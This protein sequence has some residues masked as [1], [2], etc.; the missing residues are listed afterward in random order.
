MLKKLPKIELHCH[1]DGSVRPQTIIDIAKEENIEIPSNELSEIENMVKVPLNCDS[2][3][4][5]L[6]RF[7]L[8]NKV[9]QSKESLKRI[10]FE[11]LEDANS[12]NLKYMEIRFAPLLHTL[13]GLSVSEVIES[14]IDGIKEAEKK[15]PIKAN[16]ILGCMRTMTLDDAIYV[17]EEGKKFL[18]K[19]VVAIDL[20]GAEN[21]GFA[22]EFKEAIDLARSFGYR[23]TIHAGEAASGVNVLEAVEILKA[24]RI[25]H[26]IGIRDI[27]EAYEIVK[28]KNIVLEMCPTSNVQTNAVNSFEDHPFYKFY[29]DGLKV[30]LNTDN[31]TVSNINLTK[32]F[33]NVDSVFEMSEE[34]YKNL[35]LISVDSTFADDNTKKWLRKFI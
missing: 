5:Y 24:E 15:Y 12:E 28:N 22:I 27:K 21:E 35:Y 11:L 9:M 29:K 14:I 30:T 23:V 18:N 13:N 31:R 3:V 19:G 26:G 8:P 1:L 34:D 10:T 25:G 32:E 4:E 2:L 7:D 20:C 17:V 16:L 6:K 33:N